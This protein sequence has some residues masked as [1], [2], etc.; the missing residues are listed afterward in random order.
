MA[1]A[2]PN[3]PR[4][5]RTPESQDIR[6]FPKNLPTSISF[7]FWILR[8]SPFCLHVLPNR[9]PFGTSPM[10]ATQPLKHL[11]RPSP[12]LRSL[13]IGFQTLKLQ[14][15]PMLSDYALTLSFNTT[16]N[17]KLHPIAFHSWTFSTPELNYDVH[18]KELLVIFEAFK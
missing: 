10:S 6:V 1:L 12:Q 18:D 15:R 17:G 7:H 3:H 16:S 9:V 4:L 13:P 14:S 2:V 5:A 8:K 11:K